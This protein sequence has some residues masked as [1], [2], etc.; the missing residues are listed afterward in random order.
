MAA[1]TDLPTVSRF[2]ISRKLSSCIKLDVVL[3]TC[4][5]GIKLRGRRLFVLGCIYV[6]PNVKLTEVPL[7]CFSSLARYGQSILHIIPELEVELDVPV[8]LMGDIDINVNEKHKFAVFMAC[9]FGFLH[10]PSAP[11]TTLGNTCIDHIFLRNMNTEC[12]QFVSYFS[13]HKP[14]LNGL[15]LMN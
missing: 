7:F 8:A 15:A 11:P 14:L 6:H 10:H 3:G 5:V 13:Y 9:E 2:M 4:L 1:L 12:M